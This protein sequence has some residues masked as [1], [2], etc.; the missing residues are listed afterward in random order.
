MKNKGIEVARS[1]NGARLKSIRQMASLLLFM[2]QAKG[3]TF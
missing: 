2:K 1:L 3:E